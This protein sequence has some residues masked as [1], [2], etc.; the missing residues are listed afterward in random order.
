[1]PTAQM[2]TL[3]TIAAALAAPSPVSPLPLGSSMS[4]AE[5]LGRLS[6][7][8]QNFRTRTMEMETEFSSQQRKLEV[9]FARE[10]SALRRDFQLAVARVRA[11]VAAGLGP[12]EQPHPMA[13]RTRLQDDGDG[14]STL[15]ASAIQATVALTTVQNVCCAQR[16]ET[17]SASHYPTSCDHGPECGLAVETVHRLCDSF[18]QTSLI[19]AAPLQQAADVCVATSPSDMVPV[20][21]LSDASRGGT[22]VPHA[23]F[24]I[25]RTQSD[26]QY[27]SGW[28]SLAVLSAPAGF[29]LTLTWRAFDLDDGDFIEIFDNQTALDTRVGGH[30]LEG[31]QLPAA[32]TSRSNSLLVRFVTNED[33]TSFGASADI[34]CA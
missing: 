27:R 3:V 30:R 23:C 28:N 31:R 22:S 5:M 25:L 29:Q 9:T 10:T 32:V 11:D 21:T 8:E 34:T 13:R 4:R 20:S 24:S 18:L 7:L 6:S 12:L 26:G 14:A 2:L 15:C 16:G 1:M 33:G 17:C 19:S